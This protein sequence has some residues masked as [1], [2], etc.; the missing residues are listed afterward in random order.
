MKALRIFALPVMILVL[1]AISQLGEAQDL[2]VSPAPAPTSDGSAI[3][4]GIAYLLIC[5][6]VPL[7]RYDIYGNAASAYQPAFSKYI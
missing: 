7:G 6:M 2:G 4:Q 3:D 1:L 5:D